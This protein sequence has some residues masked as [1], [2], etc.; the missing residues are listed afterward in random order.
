MHKDTGYSSGLIEGPWAIVAR[1]PEGVDQAR[2][3]PVFRT[4]RFKVRAESYAWLNKAA[5]EVNQVWNWANATSFKAA[6]PFAGRG[7]FL[8]GFDLCNLSTGATEF[9]EHIG[10]DTIQRVCTEFATRRSQLKK[11]KL[12]WRVST[13]S[14]R[15]LG[16]VP[17]KAASLRRGGRYLRFCGK[18]IRFFEAKRFSEISK[19]QSGAF[20]QDAVGDWYLCLPVAVVDQSPAPTKV[21]VGIDLGLKDTAVTS[22]GERLS[23]GVFFRSLALQIAAA[24][25]RGHKAQA[26][27]LHRGN[28]SSQRQAPPS[29]VP[30]PR[31][32]RKAPGAAAARAPENWRSPR[33]AATLPGWQK[34]PWIRSICSMSAAP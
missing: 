17:F 24:Q 12:R 19:W 28:E 1:V 25:R 16:W 32:A 6:L 11:A 33:P 3:V 30:H 4:L 9:F 22:D 18:T 13:G 27:R 20:A 14:R 34:I 31:K 8:S 15:S 21:D 7:R 26:K 5:L 29:R 10:A 2:S 23:S